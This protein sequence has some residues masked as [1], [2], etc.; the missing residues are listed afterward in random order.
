[1]H[2]K[3][4]VFAVLIALIPASLVPA[5]ASPEGRRAAVIS[6][7][8]EAVWATAALIKDRS[9]KFEKAGW[10]INFS[11]RNWVL[12]ADGY[13]GSGEFHFTVSG[14]LWGDENDDW[15]VTYSGGGRIGNEPLNI[16]GKA[17]WKYDAKTSDHG[18]M[19]F[20]NATKFGEN[21]VWGW[22]VG[23]E[24]VVG[25]TVG[26][27]GAVV[28][29]NVATAG[30]GLPASII[31]GVNGAIAGSVGVATL[32]TF[33]KDL[34]NSEGTVPSSPAPAPS[35]AAP[36]NGPLSPSKDE[37]V[38]AVSNK[39]GRVVAIGPE[40]SVVVSGLLKENTGTG[41]VSSR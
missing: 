21:S 23:T 10:S 36:N 3:H 38:I 6:T 35:P 37:V 39:E 34:I 5:H 26:Y 41:S 40:G 14:F 25:G 11:D 15:L 16:N 12:T 22:V 7:A 4:F 33:V 18:A 24:L 17:L 2:P 28:A 30:V 27:V 31:I 13:S 1:M 19:E 29:V 20:Y 8:S 9:G 32:S